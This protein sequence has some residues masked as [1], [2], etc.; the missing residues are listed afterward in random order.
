MNFYAHAQLF[1]AERASAHVHEAMAK[2]R[3]RL[4]AVL[5]VVAAEVADRDFLA[6]GRFTA[7]DLVMA[8]ILH[9]ANHLK[10]L[11]GRSRLVAYV[12]LHC[13]RPASA[14]AVS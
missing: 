8:S 13:K 4:D 11:E 9:L 6:A 10:L 12:Y 3:A 7:A 1:E 2:D 14:R 5:D